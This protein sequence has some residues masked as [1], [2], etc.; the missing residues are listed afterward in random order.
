MAAQFGYPEYFVLSIFGLVVIADASSESLLKGLLSTIIGVLITTI[1]MDSLTGLNRF[2]FGSRE[3]MAGIDQVP[4][5]IGLFG[6][7]EIIKQLFTMDKGK[8][9]YQKIGKIFPGWKLIWKL[10]GTLFR[11]TVIG[12]GVGIMPGAGGPIAAF[13]AYNSEKTNSDHPEKFGTGIPEGIAAPECANNATVGGALIPMLSLGVP[14]DGV[15]AIMMSTFAIHGLRLG[16]MIFVEQG[17]IVTGVY[18]YSIIANICMLF[19]GLFLARFFAKLL[20]L[21]KRMLLPLIL[22]TCVVGSYASSNKTFFILVMVVF[23]VLGFLLESVGVSSS[24]L[25]LGMVLGDLL[26]TNLRQSLI[27]SQGSYEIFF[28]RPICIFFWVLTVFMVAYPKVKRLI[29]KERAKAE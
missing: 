1:G 8:K 28:N 6:V 18:I 20:K 15:T 9:D 12:T 17:P 19:M 16:P 29:Q 27:L 7:S 13:V 23:G 5:L 25:I 14:G 2:A 10:K 21:D 26:E 22:I 24:P 3:L 11:S 4:V